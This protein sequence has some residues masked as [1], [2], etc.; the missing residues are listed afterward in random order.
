MVCL[1]IPILLQNGYGE[2]K[3]QEKSWAQVAV[4][5]HCFFAWILQA[6]QEAASFQA[7]CICINTV[8]ES[9][10]RYFGE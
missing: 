1:Q 2:R 4:I 3:T 6:L 7:E 5:S 9:S 8:K 10:L